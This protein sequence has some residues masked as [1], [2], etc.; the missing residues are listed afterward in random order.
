MAMENMGPMIFTAG[1]IGDTVLET[2]V[3]VSFSTMDDRSSGIGVY[4]VILRLLSADQRTLLD[5][6]FHWA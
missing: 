5:H 6:C 4:T 2:G 3:V 1:V